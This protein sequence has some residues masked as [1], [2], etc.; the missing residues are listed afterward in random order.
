M[1]P[2]IHREASDAVVVLRLDHGKVSALDVEL[3]AELDAALVE[4]AGASRALVLTGTGTA[5]SAG[6]D[7]YR[8]ID[9]GPAYVRRFLPLLDQVLHRVFLFPR[10]VVAALNGHAIAGGCILARTCDQRILASGKARLGVPELRVGVPFPVLA[11]EI[12][13]ATVGSEEIQRLAYGGATYGPEE[14]LARG[15]VDAVVPAEE[16]LGRAV[17]LADAL[18]AI[19][20]AAFALAK[21]QL[22]GPAIERAERYGR[23]MDAQVMAAWC[24]PRTP[25]VIRTYLDATLGPRS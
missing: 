4:E 21:K 19:P 14:S 24:D 25:A 20:A 12:M 13:R 2:M 23:E 9:G 10:P 22:R 18:A 7:L 8:V 5:F 17:A 3:L 16:V 15:L 6:V 11:L 1:R